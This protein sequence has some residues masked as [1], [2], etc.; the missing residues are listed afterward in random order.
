LLS[1]LTGQWDRRTLLLAALTVAAA[2]NGLSA[3]ATT[4]PMLIVGR[5]IA[6]FAAAAYT[7]AA[8]NMNRWILPRG[9][10]GSST[11]NSTCRGYL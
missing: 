6:G 7:P 11:T 5:I 1:T 4:C 2:G 9:L 8:R 3:R 10:R